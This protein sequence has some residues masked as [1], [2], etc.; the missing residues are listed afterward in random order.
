MEREAS[1]GHFG[2][3]LGPRVGDVH[4]RYEAKRTKDTETK[5]QSRSDSALR[6]VQ[7]QLSSY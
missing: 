7:P 2:Q 3:F 6:P 1:L 5:E 4:R